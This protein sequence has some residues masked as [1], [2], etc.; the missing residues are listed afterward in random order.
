[1]KN[2][3]TACFICLLL[4]VCSLT[5]LAQTLTVAAW[6]LESGDST[7][8]TLAARVRGF[9]G[10]D[11]WGFS[12]VQ[13]QS[14]LNDM[15]TAAGD[16]E[17][18]AAFR[19]ILGTTGSGDRLGI[20]Y[21]STRLQLISSEELDDINV[22]GTV[23]APLVALFRDNTTTKE[24]YFMVN[25]LYRGSADGRHEQ[26]RLLNQWA[27]G[28]NKSVIVVGDF[29]YDL[30]ADNPSDRDEGF[31]LLTRQDVFVWARPATL[32]RTQCSYNSVL[33][34]VF[35]SGEAKRWAVQAAIDARTNDCPDDANK[36][37]HRP[38]TATFTITGTPVTTVN[39]REEIL[40][41]IRG[42]E[43]QL[44]QLRVLVEQP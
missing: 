1:M 19:S 20:V 40:Q 15:T 33:D 29:N 31:N 4:I 25:H 5:A 42:L 18:G 44:R 21:N 43:E 26:S 22:S 11:V 13:N 32:V 12:E 8:P 14:V 41:R 38:I 30:N 3:K 27:A 6:N 17:T 34:F 10:V 37:D 28:Q 2:I 36:S 16:G 35:V 24:F 9:Q 7:T 39:R 23:R